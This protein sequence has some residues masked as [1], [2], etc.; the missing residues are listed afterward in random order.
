MVTALLTLPRNKRGKLKCGDHIKSTFLIFQKNS[1]CSA[2]EYIL[3]EKH[4]V[5]YLP[6]N[7]YRLSALNINVQSKFFSKA[8]TVFFMTVPIPELLCILQSIASRFI[9]LT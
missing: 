1:N 5:L 3:L 2:I 6:S 7:S 9:F 8:G 4:K